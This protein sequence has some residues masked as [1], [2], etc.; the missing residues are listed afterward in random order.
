MKIQKIVARQIYD[1]RCTPTIECEMMLNSGE[2]VRASVPHGKSKGAGEAYELGELMHTSNDA[3]TFINNEIAPKLIGK[4]PNLI[5]IDQMLIN[6]D[7]TPQKF[8]IGASTML[9]VSTAACKAQALAEGLEIYECI[10]YLYDIEM[11]YIP[12]CMFNI[13][14]GGLHAQ[15][16]IPIQEVLFMP[17]GTETFKDALH[18][19]VIV[20]NQVG[21][22]LQ[23]K[24]LD[25]SIGDEGG[26]CP[27][28]TNIEQLLDLLCTVIESLGFTSHIML[29]LD[30][31]ASYWYDPTTR[32]YNLNNTMVEADELIGWYEHLSLSYPLY[33]IEDGLSQYDW[34]G[35]SN[36]SNK[37]GNSLQLIGDDLFVTQPQRIAQGIE[38]GIANAVIIKPTQIG[39]I[40]EALQSAKLAQTYDYKAIISHRSGETDDDFIADLAVGCN[41]S[42]FK[43]G[44][45]LRGE[46]LTKYHRLLRIEERLMSQSNLSQKTD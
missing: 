16:K 23:Q 4:E 33:A 41:A 40:T 6:L 14:N 11:V 18:M 36:M 28:I 31:A 30:M 1:S 35:W 46:R 43:A 9:A 15:N 39:T 42:Q 3:I 21:K 8:K 44:G 22:L 29:A 32:L 26:Y 38:K 45:L 5:E 37:L 24:N 13:F 2:W 20:F 27:K 19:A 25:N 34:D 10:A 12:L 7:N 17:Y